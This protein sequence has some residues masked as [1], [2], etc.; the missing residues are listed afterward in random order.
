MRNQDQ[1]EIDPV[2]IDPVID[3]VVGLNPIAIDIARIRLLRTETAV[4]V[5]LLD[6][7]CP[8]GADGG[9]EPFYQP[10][11]A[12]CEPK[13]LARSRP[14]LRDERQAVIYP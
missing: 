2:R 10:P 3:A 7:G 13:P 4:D 6:A 12:R 11:A 1:L 14:A 8:K 9:T 5:N